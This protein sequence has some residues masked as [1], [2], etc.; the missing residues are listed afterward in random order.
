[1]ASFNLR[2]LLRSIGRGQGTVPAFLQT[3]ASQLLVLVVNILTGV[4]TARALGA[5]GRGIFA[6]ITF[7]PYFL[8]NLF[9]LG[10]PNALVVH[11]RSFAAM[12]RI[13][14]CI[15]LPSLSPQPA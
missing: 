11:F 4:I 5:D 9:S 10:L 2:Q 13:A 3:V 15:G 8:G 1:M 6:A 14:A 7:W 12:R